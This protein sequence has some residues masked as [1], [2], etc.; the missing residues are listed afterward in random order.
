LTLSD[1]DD[2]RYEAFE[3]RVNV[4]AQSGPCVT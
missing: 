4:A 1:L 3:N 2:Q